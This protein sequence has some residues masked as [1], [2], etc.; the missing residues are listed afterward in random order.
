MECLYENYKCFLLYMFKIIG[1]LFMVGIIIALLILSTSIKDFLN[2]CSS[3][4]LILDKRIIKY[5]PECEDY[6]N[7]YFPI[8]KNVDFYE[9]KIGNIDEFKSSINLFKDKT[10]ICKILLIVS[11]VLICPSTFISFCSLFCIPKEDDNKKIFLLYPF[12]H[13][14][15]NRF[16]NYFILYHCHFCCVHYFF[17]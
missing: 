1:K 12:V 2:E 17:N 11:L 14:L 8:E 9:Y 15:Y 5:N 16:Y 7:K 3:Y 4:G 6:I 13:N 10:T